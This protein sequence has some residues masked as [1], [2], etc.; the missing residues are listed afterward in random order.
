MAIKVT[1]EI[2]E[3]INE[4]YCQLGVKAQV[5]KAIGCSASTVS[6][7]IIPNYVPKA[8]RIQ[9]VF[10]GEP[11]DGTEFINYVAHLFNDVCNDTIGVYTLV[12]S[13]SKEEQKEME[14]LAKE[15]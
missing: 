11:D 6:K 2:I 12:G 10:E 5:A 13:L 7:Y 14:N 3:Q 15:F 8:D 1:P 4:L 9:I